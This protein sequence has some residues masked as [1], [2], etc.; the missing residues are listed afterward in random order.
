MKR[1]K[2]VGMSQRS[3]A[4]STVFRVL[5]I[6]ALVLLVLIIVAEIG[7][8]MF[9]ASQVRAGFQEQAS[10]EVTEEPEVSFGTSPLVF[11]LLGGQLNEISVNTPS[12]LVIDGDNV[13]GQPAADIQLEGMELTG[14]M[15]S[16]QVTTTTELPDDFLLATMRTQIAENRPADA[17]PF[18]EYL[19]VT[20]ITSNAAA[21]TVDVEFVEGLAALTLTPEERDGELVFTASN[22][23]VIGIDLPEQATNEITRALQAGMAEGSLAGEDM[24]FENVE[25]LDGAL[26][27][28]LVGENV[29]LKEMA[30]E[31]QPA[32]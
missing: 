16:D 8:R 22:A 5:A 32:Q 13:E 3:S 10:T 2:L 27:M 1:D 25:V 9:I 18:A 23:R 28:T 17:G 4:A 24:R 26:R 31:S 19:T 7:L 29:S 6:I 30:N 12:T 11:G 15:V 21:S 20:D 14:D